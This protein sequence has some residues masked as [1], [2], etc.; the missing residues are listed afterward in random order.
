MSKDDAQKVILL[1]GALILFVLCLVASQLILP[2]NCY[3]Y[4]WRQVGLLCDGMNFNNPQPC[5]AC[6]NESRAFMARILFISGFCLLILPFVV[7]V[8]KQRRGQPIEQPK[9][10]D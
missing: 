9:L 5:T 6:S 8:I 1:F 2:E 10:F 3:I 7:F 4:E